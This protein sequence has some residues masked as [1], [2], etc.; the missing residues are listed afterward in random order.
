M[1]S[2]NVSV[3][4]SNFLCAF[5]CQTEK[6]VHHSEHPCSIGCPYAHFLWIQ[7]LPIP[8]SIN[9]PSKL[10]VSASLTAS[11]IW[12]RD[13]ALHWVNSSD[14]IFYFH[15]QCLVVDT[16]S[17]VPHF[18]VCFRDWSSSCLT[19]KFPSSSLPISADS[20]QCSCS[21]GKQGRPTC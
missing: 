17:R 12:L 19:A 21:L 2:G 14:I 5:T 3:Q 6:Q 15:T 1:A 9:Q 10:E 20:H 4:G 13:L 18:S 11:W 8:F 7:V 16:Q